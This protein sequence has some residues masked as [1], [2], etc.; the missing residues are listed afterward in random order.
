MKALD[1]TGKRFG[2]LVAIESTRSE[3]GQRIWTCKCDCG[4]TK[5]IV[6]YSLVRGSSKSCGCLVKEKT[7]NRNYLHGKSK[8][9]IHRI[10]SSM[11]QRCYYKEKSNYKDYG[12]RGISICEE[13]M[14]FQRFYDWSVKNGYDD[15][16][17]ID[18][19]DV[20]GNYEPLNCR[21]AT[22]SQQ[23]NNT[24]SS[25]FIEY[26]NKK[27]TIA[28]W[29]KETGIAKSVIRYRL[30]KGYDVKQIFNKK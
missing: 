9:R 1:L 16:L 5:D 25:C 20:N 12:G 19:I 10:W 29:S 23:A 28:E 21:W 13:W 26:N 11:K 3:K 14:D 4:N 6:S 30:H 22:K 18:R 7:I 17:S 24:R 8:T 2:S 27:Q 15:S